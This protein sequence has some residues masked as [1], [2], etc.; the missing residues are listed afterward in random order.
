MSIGVDA[1]VFAQRVEAVDRFAKQPHFRDVRLLRL[2]DGTSQI[3]QITVA[4]H[5]LVERAV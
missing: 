1:D 5:S 4:R 3:Q 2:Y